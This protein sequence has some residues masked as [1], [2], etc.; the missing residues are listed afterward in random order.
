MCKCTPSIRTPYCGHGACIW[1]DSEKELIKIKLIPRQQW[2][3]DRVKSC[4][5]ELKELESIRDWDTYKLLAFKLSNELH[6]AVLEWEKYYN[7]S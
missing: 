4:I 1:P 7:E 6:Y 2:L 3:K 5:N